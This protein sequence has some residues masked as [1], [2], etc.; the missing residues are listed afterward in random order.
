MFVIASLSFLKVKLVQLFKA[1]V[2]LWEFSVMKILVVTVAFN[3]VSTTG[4]TLGSALNQKCLGVESLGNNR[5][6]TNQ[7]YPDVGHIAIDGE[8]VV[9]TVALVKQLVNR[10]LH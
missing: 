9:S 7:T 2:F 6:G 5:I 8:S 4:D 1:L 10:E 3:S